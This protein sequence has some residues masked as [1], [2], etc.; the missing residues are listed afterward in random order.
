MLAQCTHT[1][2]VFRRIAKIWTKYDQPENDYYLKINKEKKPIKIANKD[3]R[4]AHH[5]FA[6]RRLEQ[7]WI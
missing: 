3:K 6:L 1:F 5:H 7:F 2:K 4:V